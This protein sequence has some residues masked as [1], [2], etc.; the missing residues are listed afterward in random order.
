MKIAPHIEKTNVKPEIAFTLSYDNLW[1]FDLEV[2]YG[3]KNYYGLDSWDP[4]LDFYR[5]L[6]SKNLPVD[7]VDPSKEDLS[8]YKVVFVPSLMLIDEA[9]EK[10]LRS[11]VKKGGILIA[12]TRTG[13]KDWNNV[14]VDAALPGVLSDL[15]G[16]T[17]EEYTGLP[18]DEK[19]GIE[20]NETMLSRKVAGRGRCW[21]EMLLPKEDAKIVAY[22]NMGIYV[23]KPAATINNYG[24]GLAIYIGSF[25]DEI[26]YSAIL[27][28]L[29]ER[30]KIEPVLPSTEGLEAVERTGSNGRVIFALN[31]SERMIQVP[32]KR[33][34]YEI[35]SG[36][37]VDGLLKIEGLDAKV[38]KPIN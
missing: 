35:L 10:N 9:A 3:G 19:V 27:D 21:A 36:E 11:Y 24:E 8:K 1:A 37:K 4:S 20:T 5:V 6:Y 23:G 38:L 16:I 29:M 14:I 34:Y 25:P 30:L 15:F 22:Y 17:V 13:A 28:W 31:H 26:L 18:D 32:L 2:G 12:T 33:E 7:F